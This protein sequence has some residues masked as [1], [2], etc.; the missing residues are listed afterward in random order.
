MTKKDNELKD[1]INL[2]GGYEFK[3]IEGH[4]E[5]KHWLTVGLTFGNHFTLIQN[6]SE[7]ENLETLLFRVLGSMGVNKF[8]LSDKYGNPK[9]PYDGGLWWRTS[10]RLTN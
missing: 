2:L 4:A 6:K 10:F 3:F 7:F 8:T 9:N 1:T 5:L